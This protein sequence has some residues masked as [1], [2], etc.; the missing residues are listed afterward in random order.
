MTLTAHPMRSSRENRINEIVNALKAAHEH[1]SHACKKPLRDMPEYF[2][3]TRVGEHF[4]NRFSNFGYN[5]EASVAEILEQAGVPDYNQEALETFPELRQ[6]GRF[7]L[8]LLTRK[9]G[10]PAHIIEFKKGHN[11]A[12]LKKDIERLARLADAV[13][14]GSRLETSYLVFITKRT[15]SRTMSDWNERLQEIVSESLI[16]QGKIVNDVD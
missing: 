16:G 4:F 14:Q 2:M 5:L 7:D 6:N 10:R 3:G 9:R 11:L 8:V 15:L 12:E 1:S 13:P